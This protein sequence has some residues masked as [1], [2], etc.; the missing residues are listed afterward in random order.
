MADPITPD[1]ELL[2]VPDAEIAA[3]RLR[4]EEPGRTRLGAADEQLVARVQ[5][6]LAMGFD[7]LAGVR[8]AV[9]VFGSARTPATDH[10]YALARS[11]AARLGQ[12]GI[13]II[14]G[15]GPG[16][17]EAANLGARDAGAL[18]IGLTIDLPGTET[19]NAYLDLP[20]HFHY[21]FARKVMFVRY[22]AAFVVF[23]GGLGTLDEL[24]ELVTLIQTRKIHTPPVALVGRAYWEPLLDWLR[25]TV[26]ASGKIS[27]SDIYL[28]DVADDIEQIC[29][30]IEPALRSAIGQEPGGVP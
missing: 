7:A 14:T 25:D 2:A 13:A 24:F 12:D 20:V 11:L 29:A 26:L 16:I 21:F 4:E 3:F 27:P 17:M 9:S 23:P 1:E 5:A 28:F 6:E 18:S 10:D 22:S 19:V 30:H 15:G 8:R